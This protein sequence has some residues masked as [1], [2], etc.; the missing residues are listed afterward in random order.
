[1]STRKERSRQNR[2]AHAVERA[3][4]LGKAAPIDPLDEEPMAPRADLASIP[5]NKV[6][7]SDQAREAVG[8]AILEGYPRN[9]IAKALGTTVATLRRLITEDEQLSDAVAV[10]KDIE[11]QELKDILMGLARKG[12]TVAAIFVAKA[13]F[14]WRDRP[15][16]KK[17]EGKVG[18]VLVLP[19]SPESLEDFE[20]AAYRQQ[21]QYR[22]KLVEEPAPREVRTFTRGGDGLRLQRVLPG[23]RL[24]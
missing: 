23:D 17:F 2:Q 21:A 16:D 1:M 19:A 18:G 7:L 12:D 24:N 9:Q 3:T 22:Q 15:E 6:G 5:W 4:V 10:R 8:L 14:G 11:E 13:Q 20:A